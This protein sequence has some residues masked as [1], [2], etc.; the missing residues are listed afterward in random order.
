LQV[1]RLSATGDAE[2]CDAPLPQVSQ[3]ESLIRPTVVGICGT[4]LH[5]ASLKELFRPGTVLGHEL[6]GAVISS[7][8][9]DLTP[10][11]RVVVNPNGE[12]C[13]VCR[14]CLA[15][16]ANLCFRATRERC[17]GVQR[18]G[19][20]ADVVA[21]PAS[22]LHAVGDLPDEVAVWTEPL[23]AAVRAVSTCLEA[24]PREV[25]VLGGGPVGLLAAQLLAR[26]EVDRLTVFEPRPDRLQIGRGLGLSMRVPPDGIGPPNCDAVLDCAGTAA[27]VQAAIGIVRPAGRIVILGVPGT[28]VPIDVAHL[29][30]NE[31]VLRGS[32]IYSDAEFRRALDLLHAGAVA[33]APLVGAVVSLDEFVVVYSRL[34]RGTNGGQKVLV[35]VSE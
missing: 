26:A 31:I 2:F 20:L 34:R 17:V 29:V 12:L 7:A 11:Q 33:T 16:R 1:V 22:S 15:G 28:P 24:E 19:G 3:A 13:G 10:G 9:P 30:L 18:D 25:A 23:A 4:D 32:M 35:R 5:A 14:E 27:S 6:V 21:V 8:R